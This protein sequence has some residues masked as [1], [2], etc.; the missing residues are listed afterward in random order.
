[1]KPEDCWILDGSQYLRII[2]NIRWFITSN[3]S[4]HQMIHNFKWFTTPDDSY[5]LQ[6]QRIHNIEWFPWND[7]QYQMILIKYTIKLSIPSKYNYCLGVLVQQRTP[8]CNLQPRKYAN[9][10]QGLP[11]RSHYYWYH[12]NR[13]ENRLLFG[14]R[15]DRTLYKGD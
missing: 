13:L 12:Q 14:V 5:H 15:W 9:E 10:V 8:V 11:A 7:L 1:M 2:C 6:H 4:Q 3:D